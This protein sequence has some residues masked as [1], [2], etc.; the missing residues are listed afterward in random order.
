MCVRERERTTETETDRNRERKKD[1]EDLW[2]DYFIHLYLK[3]KLP[4]HSKCHSKTINFAHVPVS[5]CHSN[6]ILQTIPQTLAH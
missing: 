6:A 1:W 5:Y 3:Q 4:P 2:L